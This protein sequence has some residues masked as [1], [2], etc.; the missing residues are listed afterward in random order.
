M[1]QRLAVID[2]RVFWSRD[3]LLYNAY[4]LNKLK[5]FRFDASRGFE[6]SAANTASLQHAVPTRG[7]WL[8][9]L[10]ISHK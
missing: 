7:V 10:K 9:V 3:F 5:I 4:E 2:N 6:F 8:G 1:W